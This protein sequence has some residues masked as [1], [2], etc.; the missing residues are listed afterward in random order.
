MPSFDFNLSIALFVTMPT[1][2]SYTLLCFLSLCCVMK[3]TYL[4][5]GSVLY[6]PFWFLFF[7]WCFYAHFT[8]ATL[9]WLLLHISLAPRKPYK[10]LQSP[11][12]DLW[13]RG[14]KQDRIFRPVTEQHFG[15]LHDSW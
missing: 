12:K 4:E 10:C 8:E 9:L 5:I 15:V 3:Q 11:S 14:I 6:T 7:F 13:Y 1:F 2:T